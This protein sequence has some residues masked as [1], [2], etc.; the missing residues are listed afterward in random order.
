M[1]LR[2]LSIQSLILVLALLTATLTVAGCGGDDPSDDLQNSGDASNNDDVGNTEDDP[3]DDD[4]SGDDDDDDDNGDDELPEEA[5]DAMNDYMVCEDDLDCPINGSDCIDTI[6]FNRTDHEGVDSHWVHELFDDVDEGQG[7]CSR[8]CAE[9]P[10]ICDDVHWTDGDDQIQP[11]T[12]HVVTTGAEPYEVIEQDPFEVETDATEMDRGQ[13]FGAIC[14]PPVTVAGTSSATICDG[15][16]TDDD[17]GDDSLCYNAL[18]ATER[19]SIDELGDSF[20]VAPCETD[21]DCPMGFD[22]DA[23]DDDQSYCLPVEDT[24]TDCIDRDENGYGTG[25]CGPEGDRQTGFDCD[26]EN[27]DAYYDPDDSDHPFYDHCYDD[28][29]QDGDLVFNDLN[30]SG[31]LDH[32]ELV[33]PDGQGHEH[34]RF[35]N[36]SCQGDVD[37]AAQVCQ[38]DDDGDAQCGLDCQDG[39]ATCNGDPTDGCDIPKA[40]LIAQADSA[41]FYHYSQDGNFDYDTDEKSGISDD[42]SPYIWFEAD[43]ADDDW[44]TADAEPHFFCDEAAAQ[45]ELGELAVRRRGCEET[46]DAFP[47]GVQIC[48]D[49][50]FNCSGTAGDGDEIAFDPDTDAQEGDS[51]QV[52]GEQGQ[53]A[54][55]TLICGGNPPSMDCQQTAAAAN[56]PVSAPFCDDSVDTT[57]SGETD[58]QHDGE[59][60]IDDENI[61]VFTGYDADDSMDDWIAQFDEDADV[62]EPSTV[63]PGAPCRVDGQQGQCAVGVVQCTSSGLACEQVNDPQ[64]EEPGFDGIDHSCDGFDRYMDGDDPHIVYVHEGSDSPT[65]DQ[66]I[67]DAA[68]CDGV[69]ID[70][71]QIPCDVFVRDRQFSVDATLEIPDG[72]HIYGGFASYEWED[73]DFDGPNYS[74]QSE[75]VVDAEVG[76][77]VIDPSQRT[78]IYGLDVTTEDAT[79]TGC[80]PNVGM[81]CDNCDELRLKHFSVTAGAARDAGSDGSHGSD[82]ANGDP[83]VAD[84]ASSPEDLNAAGGSGAPHDG[85]SG[86]QD[87][88][89]GQPAGHGGLAAEFSQTNGGDGAHGQAP[90]PLAP[91]DDWTLSY[92]RFT[93]PSSS[94]PQA[95]PGPLP[96]TAHGGGGGGSAESILSGPLTGW[97]ASGGGGGG[98]AGGW[99]EGGSVGSPSIG[100]LLINSTADIFVDAVDTMASSGGAGSDGGDGGDGGDGN[101]SLGQQG[102]SITGG[103]G[104]DGAGGSAGPGGMGGSSIGVMLIDTPLPDGYSNNVTF[105]SGGPGASGQPG[106]PGEPGGDGDADA[107]QSVDLD[108]MPDPIGCDEFVIDQSPGISFSADISAGGDSAAYC[109][110]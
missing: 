103:T 108:D 24:C 36:D 80:V 68:D 27:P 45:N 56:Y 23:V 67:D 37:Q 51:C 47:G 86:G 50:D 91:A 87:A 69:T 84:N 61:E 32:E 105:I 100:L 43:S 35:C 72:L 57:C 52:D 70:G 40:S 55:G 99:G 90:S 83:G 8:N 28:E 49:L 77:E 101:I 42:A 97:G 64:L 88:E 53:C 5:P 9:D 6:E 15:C 7:V 63:H 78:I 89:D 41:Y 66:A 81:I 14:R 3:D 33:G 109:D 46:A 85:G 60:S 25:H 38:F 54:Q 22:C 82:G 73:D 96:D 74:S 4:D 62:H 1:S 75:V 2:H 92:N 16:A 110:D 30:C 102:T 18:T 29:D 39:Y 65:L 106:T 19:Q 34:C 31:T 44:A 48:S 94:C 11:S 17:C 58:D 79:D 59:F 13:A 93:G 26:D 76:I 107:G 95:S 21:G 104:G 98:G 12:C 10:T 20:C 71:Q